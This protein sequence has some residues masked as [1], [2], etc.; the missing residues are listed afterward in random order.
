VWTD[1]KVIGRYRRGDRTSEPALDPYGLVL[2]GGTWYVVGRAA[3][4]RFLVFRVDRFENVAIRE[5]RFERDEGFGL[6][7]FW[8]AQSEE[9]ERSL[10]TERITVRLT[11]TGLRRLP[12][13]MDPEAID[14]ATA[15]AGE[16]DERGLVTLSVP[17]ESLI[18]AFTQ[19]QAL[20]AEAEVLEPAE[21]RDRMADNADRL[22]ALYRP[23]R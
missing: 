4:G 17:V 5:E 13:A 8:D 6:A 9:F 14:E 3:T 10:L 22:H 7:A 11:P 12:L 2:K 15:S 18:V 19:L 23:Q 21:L 20:G 16:P 1:H